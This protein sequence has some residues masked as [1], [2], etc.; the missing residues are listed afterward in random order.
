VFFVLNSEAILKLTGRTFEKKGVKNLIVKEMAHGRR[1]VASV[2]K[3][4][5]D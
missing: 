5:E 3:L 1:C 2:E 4:F